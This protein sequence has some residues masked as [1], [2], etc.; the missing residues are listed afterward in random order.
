MPEWINFRDRLPKNGT[1]TV[2]RSAS[3][4][5]GELYTYGR[6]YFDPSQAVWGGFDKYRKTAQWKRDTHNKSFKPTGNPPAADLNV[7]WT[8]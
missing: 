7:G 8:K 2:Q 6:F 5:P 3:S 1:F 4:T